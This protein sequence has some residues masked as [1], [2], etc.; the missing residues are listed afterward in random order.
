M[1]GCR[2]QVLSLVLLDQME[3]L[4]KSRLMVAFIDF[5]KAYGRIDKGQ[6]GRA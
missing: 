2:D 5:S 3:M 6:Y 1:R 4:K